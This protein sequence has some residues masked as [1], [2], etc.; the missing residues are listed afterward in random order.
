MFLIVGVAC[1]APPSFVG[2]TSDASA[3]AGPSIAK[4]CTDEAMA[5]CTEL[6]SCS[7]VLI[8]TRYGSAS[9]CQ[10]RVAESCV[11]G[12][13]APSTGNSAEQVEDCAQAYSSWACS[14]FLENMN[15]PAPCAQRMG[16]FANGAFCAFPG[17][18]ASGF[19]A[20]PEAETCGVCA[21]P[22]RAGDS[23]VNLSTCGQQLVCLLPARVCGTLGALD[24]ACSNTAP[25]GPHLS[26][27]G[28]DQAKSILGKCQS[29]ASAPGAACDPTLAKGPGC[30]F[31]SGLTCN[32]QSKLCEPLTVSPPGGPCNS[33][34]HQFAACES[35]GTCSTSAAGVTG[36][37]GA[38]A[39]DGEAC[40]TGAGGPT[41]LPPARCI[42]AVSGSTSG[43]CQLPDSSACK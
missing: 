41:C 9:M 17:Q 40:T 19:C 5:Q 39:A 27:I 34:G 43:T 4:A 38:A 1:S 28:A 11:A 36:V 30:D 14:D 42:V 20:I 10:T 37:C 21:P 8:G 23:C 24:E 2:P 3:E 22:P 7:N 12:L 26:C 15:V 16:S 31:D 18:C 6:A 32:A 29:S 33:F 35:S 13:M 25:C